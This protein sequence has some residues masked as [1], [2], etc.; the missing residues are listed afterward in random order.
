MSDTIIKTE[1]VVQ[2]EKY[3]S[4]YPDMLQVVLQNNTTEDIK[5]A[6]VA[7]VA[8]DK[9]NLHVK[10]EGQLDFDGGSY[11]KKVNYSDI[12]LAGG[13]TFGENNGFS[14]GK[15]CEIETFKAVVVSYE[16]FAGEIWENP[17][18]DDFCT[19]Y[20]GQ[21]LNGKQGG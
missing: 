9:N 4:L 20:E 11:V 6:V 14:L 18:Y 21:K 12:N 10:I 3:K 7:F 13:D 1:Y 17:F 2:D 15:N 16:T 5:N 19:L 8:W